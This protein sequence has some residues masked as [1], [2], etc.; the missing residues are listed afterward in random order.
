MSLRDKL[1]QYHNGTRSDAEQA[2]AHEDALWEDEI[3]AEIAS[4]DGY[5]DGHQN[6]IDL[7]ESKKQAEIELGIRKKHSDNASDNMIERNKLNLTTLFEIAQELNSTLELH[8]LLEI[9]LYTCIGQLG[10]D[11][12]SI[13]LS[14]DNDTLRLKIHKGLDDLTDKKMS[15]NQNADFIQ[16]LFKNARP[17]A[18]T[19]L[20]SDIDHIDDFKILQAAQTQLV[21][22]LISKD[23]PVGIF[24]LG[25]RLTETHYSESDIEFA[26]TIA[27]FAAIAIEN[28][29]L[30]NS[31]METNTH[32]DNKL[33][34][35]STLY[36]IAGIMNT[37]ND[38]HELLSLL[39]ET[40]ATGFSVAQ[41]AIILRYP[42]SS[43]FRCSQSLGLS[44]I[45]QSLLTFTTNDD[46]Y[47]NYLNTTTPIRLRDIHTEPWFSTH[48]ALEDIPNGDF[49]II[50]LIAGGKTLGMMLLLDFS[51]PIQEGIEKL[52][53]IIAS[54]IAPQILAT[55]LLEQRRSEQ[56]DPFSP[57]I[58][59]L[60]MEIH[61]AEE[62][63]APV[64]LI[65]IT[66]KNYSELLAQHTAREIEQFINDI[67][68][69]CAHISG[70]NAY[71][72]RISNN[73]IITII[74]GAGTESCM[75]YIESMKSAMA[76]QESLNKPEYSLII[77]FKHAHFPDNGSD[78]LT[79]THYLNT[80]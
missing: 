32:L 70:E 24:C 36:D 21:V 7:K 43:T 79:L 57:L 54:Q 72:Y 19:D 8:R 15:I 66:I 73:A 2:E 51:N 40:L 67:Q 77:T 50:P 53:S 22:P 58:D 55:L 49:F 63:D 78:A 1:Q 46:I 47:L 42:N 5:I 44:E 48:L 71:I 37:S 11:T 64:G 18:I 35:L 14:E 65:K 59:T 33:A 27:G 10:T 76:S 6:L 52:F 17:V 61:R 68:N 4:H 3:N 28:A 56:R 45:S 29:R 31:L 69:I 16:W 41:A 13:F 9:L 30:L 75:T 60:T 23:K 20:P 74:P 39:T 26:S 80:D 38:L 25:A 62:F 12:V 34:E